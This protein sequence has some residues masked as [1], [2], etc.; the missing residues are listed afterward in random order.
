MVLQ[1]LLFIA[2]IAQ[3]VAAITAIRLATR[4]KFNAAWILFFLAIVLLSYQL[5][6]EIF[7]VIQ[8]KPLSYKPFALWSTVILSL[9]VAIGIFYT[10]KIIDYIETINRQRT[11]TE[12]RLLNTIILTEEKE[13][14]RF[15]KDLHDGLGPLLSSAKMSLSVLNSIEKDKQSK[16]IIDNTAYVIN[17]AIKGLKDV[18]N[19]ISPTILLNFGLSRA[20]NNFVSKLTLP[21][22]MNIDFSS[23]VKE[24]RFD[25]N[26]ET[27][28]YRVGCEM[29][30]NAI[31]HSEAKN[32]F[33][34]IELWGHKLLMKVQDD[35][36]GIPIEKFEDEG[37]GMGLKNIVSRINSLDG[38]V[39][40]AETEIGTKIIVKVIV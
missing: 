11:L 36:I 38:T 28:F 14:Q 17:E 13:R 24:K 19:N 16:E 22:T 25:S 12:R 9:C 29:I 4:T 26:V 2:L 32:I 31:R 1:I 21:E 3:I 10:R 6:G 8:E 27:V 20:M 33:V 30:N 35:G 5:I 39:E 37:M 15:S 18:S 23:N 40:F 7:K 34:S